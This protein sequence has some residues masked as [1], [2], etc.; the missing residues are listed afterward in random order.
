MSVPDR[1]TGL[2][3]TMLGSGPAFLLC[4]TFGDDS[5]A[6]ASTEIFRKFVKLRIAVNLDGLLGGI[7]NYV[8]VVTPGEVVLQFSLGA[9]ID[10]A[11]EIVG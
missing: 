4:V 3:T 9:G 6:E 10:R 8:A 5:G 1:E 7:A 11:V 2:P